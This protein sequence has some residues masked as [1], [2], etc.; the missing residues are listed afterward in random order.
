MKRLMTIMLVV[1]VCLAV[2]SP[3]SA[4][5]KHKKDT[6]PPKLDTAAT[7]KPRP[8][9]LP[10]SQ[11]T[12]SGVIDTLKTT[13]QRKTPPV[14]NDFIDVNRNGIDD[15][16]EQ[17]GYFVPPK[18]VPKTLVITKKADSTKAVLPKPATDK[19]EKKGK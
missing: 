3:L 17:G 13:K 15:R 18:Q 5:E 10:Q 6:P 19:S 1:G 9:S 16:L 12:G 2:A 7:A 4:I 11:S 8:E 14:F